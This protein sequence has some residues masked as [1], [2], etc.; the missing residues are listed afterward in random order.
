M[1]H[2]PILINLK[3]FR[4]KL[5]LKR[6]VIDSLVNTYGVEITSY[7]AFER[8]CATGN[9][10]LIFDGFDE[11]SDS[12]DHQTI[13]D[14]FN[15]IYLMAVLQVKIILTCRSNFFRST[16]EII[17]LLKRFSISLPDEENNQILEFSLNEQGHI[18][19][20]EKLNDKQIT[21]FVE[22]RFETNS[23]EIIKTIKKIHDL[24]DFKYTPS[25]LRYDFINIT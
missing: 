8:I 3:D 21:E 10:V 13:I 18:F 5:D 11:M 16:E 12:S 24:L 6:V 22:K 19:Y 9:I 4:G 7:S 25:T 14:T 2:T 15:Q 23:K 17:N 20:L 1:K